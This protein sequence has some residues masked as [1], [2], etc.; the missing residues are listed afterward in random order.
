M[1]KV[2]GGV[3]GGDPLESVGFLRVEGV[4]S[5][6]LQWLSMIIIMIFREKKEIW[7]K[8]DTRGVRWEHHYGFKFQ[9]GN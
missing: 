8:Q 2:S 9:G 4:I 6:V 7:E 5:G 1:C 3:C